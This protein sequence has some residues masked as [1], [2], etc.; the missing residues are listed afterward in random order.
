MNILD[1]R[2]RYTPAYLTT[3]EYLR[4]RMREWREQIERQKK[5]AKPKEESK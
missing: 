1:K 5:D 4:A 3:P 2:F